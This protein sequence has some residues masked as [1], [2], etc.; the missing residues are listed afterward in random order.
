[1][2]NFLTALAALV[3]ALTLL[4]AFAGTELAQKAGRARQMMGWAA[5]GI[6]GVLLLRGSIAAA[7][8][9]LGA[10]AF[11]LMQR[12]GSFGGLGLPWF[13]LSMFAK[14][15]RHLTPHLDVMAQKQTGR[16]SGMVIAGFFKGRRIEGL[17]PV[18]L[19]HLW[20]DCQVGDAKSAALIATH[21]DQCAPQW[22]AHLAGGT[23]AQAS[24]TAM[25]AAQ[26][27]DIL[28]LQAGATETD[29]RRAHKDLMLKLHPDR[30]GSH[31]LATTVNAAKDTLLG[32]GRM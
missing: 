16:L 21:L 32:L 26:A 13:F 5:V 17:K 9:L 15:E 8:G 18:E 2:Q 20:S 7:V 11:A 6:G 3:I 31:T 19:V 1:M 10:G 29:V 23:A 28:G 30:G 25:T 22:R 14:G 24:A 4:Q 12:P 27:L